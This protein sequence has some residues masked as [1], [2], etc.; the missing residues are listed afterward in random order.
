MKSKA[1]RFTAVSVPHLAYRPWRAVS[2]V[3][4]SDV[5]FQGQR[6]VAYIEMTLHKS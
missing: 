6:K 2:E 3:S 5:R 1:K 4:G